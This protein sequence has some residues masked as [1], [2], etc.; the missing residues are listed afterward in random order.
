MREVVPEVMEGEIM[1]VY[2]LVFCRPRFQ[3][4]EPLVN[5]LF[6]Q[7]IAPLRGK[8]VGS[9]SFTTC[10]Q[11]FIERFARFIHQISIAPLSAF[12]TNM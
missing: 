12:V 1:D 8:D 4:T 7:A 2:P 5:A 10:S 11:I 6:S 3:R 9:I